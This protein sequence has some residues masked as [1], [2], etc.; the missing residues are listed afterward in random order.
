MVKYKNQHTHTQNAQTIV[1]I[2]LG[3]VPVL[4]IPPALQPSAPVPYC[5][6]RPMPEA[7]PLCC[8]SL[9]LSDP[10]LSQACG[11]HPAA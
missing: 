4:S 1:C 11:Y 5:S 3:I 8:G 10:V 2:L 6:W 7:S 9:P